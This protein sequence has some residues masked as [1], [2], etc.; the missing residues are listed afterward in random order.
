MSC[1]I[2]TKITVTCKT[3]FLVIKAK[4]YF[5]V[6][7]VAIQYL[8]IENKWGFGTFKTKNDLINKYE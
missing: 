8:Q 3:V 4:E 2:K 7:Q 1:L 5:E 6:K